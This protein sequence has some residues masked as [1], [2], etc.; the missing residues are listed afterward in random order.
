MVGRRDLLLLLSVF[1][2]LSLLANYLLSPRHHFSE[3]IRKRSRHDA[4]SSR[5]SSGVRRNPSFIIRESAPTRNATCALARAVGDGGLN[6]LSSIL[7]DGDELFVTFGSSNLA[8][9]V[10][11]LLSSLA[12]VGVSNLLVGALDESL[13]IACVTACVP[14][15]RIDEASTA[16]SRGGEY[17]RKDYS[18]FK[19][20]GVLKTRFLSLL[21]HAAPTISVWVCDADVAF[22]SKPSPSQLV[23]S[24]S[25]LPADVLL[26]TDCLDL[27]ADDRGDCYQSS[28]FNTGILYLRGNRKGAI[29]FVD[30]WADR[31]AHVGP[32]PWL[33]DQAV[34]NEMARERLRQLPPVE[35]TGEVVHGENTVGPEAQEEVRLPGP[36]GSRLYTAAKGIATIGLL[37][38]TYIANGHTFFVQS[39]CAMCPRAGSMMSTGMPSSRNGLWCG[40]DRC[41]LE[42]K[43]LPVA[44]HATYQYGDAPTFA[45]G[46][47]TRFV[48]AGL[49]HDGPYRLQPSAVGSSNQPAAISALSRD[50]ER[51]VVLDEAAIDAEARA[52]VVA[53]GGEASWSSQALVAR[54]KARDASWRQ[55]TLSLL[56]FA[57]ATNR[58]AVLPQ[59][60]CYC[61]A[62][63]GAMVGCRVKAAHASMSLPFECPIDHLIEL[64]SWYN[65]G[66]VRW[67]PPRFLQHYYPQHD[68]G[69]RVKISADSLSSSGGLREDGLLAA[70][71]P[72]GVATAA[73]VE[74]SLPHAER[75]L[76]GFT[77]PHL[78]ASLRTATRLLRYSRLFCFSEGAPPQTGEAAP[79]CTDGSLRTAWTTDED[80][81]G[82]GYYPCDWGYQ[83][84]ESLIGGDASGA[85]AAATAA[86]PTLDAADKKEEDV[87]K[88]RMTLAV[89]ALP[90]STDEDDEYGRLSS[91]DLDLLRNWIHLASR[92]TSGHSSTSLLVLSLDPAA[93][94]E[95]LQHEGVSNLVLPKQQSSSWAS[96]AAGCVNHAMEVL[97][98]KSTPIV[99]S[100]PS[101]AWLRDPSEWIACDGAQSMLLQCAPLGPADVMVATE[102]LSVRQDA[103]FGAGHAK[104]GALD[105]SVLILKP[106]AASRTLATAWRDKLLSAHDAMSEGAADDQQNGWDAHAGR[107][108]K[109]LIIEENTPWPSLTEKPIIGVRQPSR[110]YS[111]SRHGGGLLGVLPLSSFGHGHSEWIQQGARKDKG[112]MIALRPHIAPL[113]SSRDDA[114]MIRRR[115]TAA[116]LWMGLNSSI[117][118]NERLIALKLTPFASLT[119]IASKRPSPID[120]A[121]LSALHAHGTMLGMQLRALKLT[122]AAALALNR[123]LIRPSLGCYCD[124]DPSAQIGGLLTN[125]C[126]LPSGES[127]DFLPFPCPLEHILDEEAWE[128]AAAEGKVPAILQQQQPN[129]DG[130]AALRVVLR[131]SD[132]GSAAQ[133]AERIAL[134][135]S[136]SAGG[137]AT[138]PHLIEIVW[139]MDAEIPSASTATFTPIGERA[140]AAEEGAVS[141]LLSRGPKGGW[142]VSCAHV[143]II[144]PLLKLGQLVDASL[145][146]AQ[147]I[148]TPHSAGC[149]YCFNMTRLMSL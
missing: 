135:I 146:T 121:G 98:S 83:A 14:S 139:P 82:K 147:H 91:D 111:A 100:M 101:V 142:C 51:F 133:L 88:M 122:A 7:A 96:V 11:N 143:E 52:D 116:G 132:I 144:P 86:A 141:D 3:N 115:L 74:L 47:H 46:K 16:S 6:R 102:M 137:S 107:L 109:E 21:L 112:M 30:A 43:A 69:Q 106:T 53:L 41:A 54:H 48:Q 77:S 29:A 134:T 110:L 128:D 56:A 18:A 8:P 76:C 58:T 37:P 10:S 65:Q 67:R 92:A 124:R 118:T 57:I 119:A 5:A 63:W 85:C 2:L 55:R 19:K 1:I 79:C 131:A 103:Q 24:P 84:P 64:Q 70:L 149:T 120:H 44:V 38:L 97:Q 28:Q 87:S 15:V 113:L 45:Y 127:E 114:K 105:P 59:A 104:W 123:K 108:F 95:A 25:L 61:D 80:P 93:A 75:V 39:Q 23:N 42:G 117:A 32:E 4:M 35:F 78:Q 66:A 71:L 27:K 125:G 33:D 140:H 130:N 20:M 138:P 22:I 81:R 129:A 9:F 145:K 68:S 26:S 99:L 148:N 126:K 34:L 136:S 36:G 89:C 60:F 62:F 13:H 17:I 40:P 72:Q 94:G 73:V 90:T 31:M 49:W 50:D 12:S